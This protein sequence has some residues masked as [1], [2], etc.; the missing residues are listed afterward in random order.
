MSPVTHHNG[1]RSLTLLT[2][3]LVALAACSNPVPVVEEP[4]HKVVFENA[5]FRIFEVNV[6]PGA[7]TEEHEHS[8]DVATVSMNAGT[9]TRVRVSGEDWNERPPRPMGDAAV[10]EWAGKS[11]SHTI[12]NTGKAPYLLFAVENLRK[13]GW[14]TAP[15]VTGKDTTLDEDGRAFKVYDVRL[16]GKSQGVSHT[17]PTPTLLL[18]IAGEV[19]SEGTEVKEAKPTLPSGVK[20][21]DQP[22][23]WVYIPPGQPHYLARRTPADVRIVELELR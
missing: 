7:T 9:E 6:P 11:G 15:P 8:L 10:T 14:S 5:D 4:H 21:L 13:D 12:E 18:L 1:I 17:H 16:S 3:S 22:G 20:Q 23:Q 19:I 2:A